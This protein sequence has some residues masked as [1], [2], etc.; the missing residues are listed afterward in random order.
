V[1]GGK[2]ILVK[3]NDSHL[4]KGQKMVLT[5]LLAILVGVIAYSIAVW[6][7]ASLLLSLIVAIVAVVL[8]VP[9]ARGYSGY[10]NRPRAG[11]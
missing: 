2:S 11:A 5:I 8:C 3:R 4:I 9:A 6:L 1:F 10:N 7:G